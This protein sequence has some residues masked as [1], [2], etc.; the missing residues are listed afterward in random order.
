MIT[1]GLTGSIGMGKSTTAGFFRQLGVRVHDSD[2]AV[3]AIYNGP[4]A[5]TIEAMFPGVLVDGKVDRSRLGAIVLGK[6]SAMRQL[7]G[8]IHPLVGDDRLR[9]L[10]GAR[11]RGERIVVVDIPLLFEIG[12][13]S[14]VDVVLVASA[15]LSVQRARVLSRPGM[16][17]ER[18]ESILEKQIPDHVKRARAHCVVD[19]GS[20]LE[21]A[22]LQ[23]QSLV[24]ALS[25]LQ[26][27]GER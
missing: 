22:A 13:D 20:G 5:Q 23:V 27:A 15:P 9:F 10:A 14:Q 2:A 6:P 26:V 18:F 3:H 1:I 4:S 25:S 17:V 24:R 21:F 7:E 16:T 19:T 11:A 8:I 12:G